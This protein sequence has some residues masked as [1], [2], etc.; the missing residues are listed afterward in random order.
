MLGVCVVGDPRQ[1]R[2]FLDECRLRGWRRDR[3]LSPSFAVRVVRRALEG[4]VVSVAIYVDLVSDEFARHC[5]EAG[6]L[7]N[8][9]FV[10]PGT[11]DDDATSVRACSLALLGLRA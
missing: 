3:G 6:H 5:L 8:I 9:T 11:C 4:D 1:R 2:G 7:F 10:S